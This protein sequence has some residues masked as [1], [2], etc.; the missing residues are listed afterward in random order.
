M[1]AMVSP[2]KRQKEGRAFFCGGVVTNQQAQPSQ[3][4]ED[5]AD[6]IAIPA[7]QKADRKVDRGKE[8]QQLSR[9]NQCLRND[10]IHGGS[11]GWRIS[12]G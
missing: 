5:L 11:F 12:D 3:A 10:W 1:R 2:A 9:V 6:A 8:R 4:S 7:F